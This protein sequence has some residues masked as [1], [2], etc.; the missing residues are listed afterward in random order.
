VR[1]KDYEAGSPK[2]YGMEEWEGDKL[3]SRTV[4]IHGP[5]LAEQR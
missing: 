2:E 1:K 3:P 4:V 5:D